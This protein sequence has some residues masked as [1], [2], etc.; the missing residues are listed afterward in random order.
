MTTGIKLV[1]GKAEFEIKELLTVGDVRNI[2][3]KL[4][5]L[6][7]AAQDILSAKAYEEVADISVVIA[8]KTE[9]QDDIIFDTLLAHIVI[10]EDLNMMKCIE[11]FHMIKQ[12]ASESTI[13]GN[14]PHS[15]GELSTRRR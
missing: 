7:K 3:K 10:A 2:R 14:I 4:N 6:T 12:S 11:S 13:D 9:E 1:V 15:G 8:S 5:A